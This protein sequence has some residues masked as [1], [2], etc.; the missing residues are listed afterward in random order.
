MNKREQQRKIREE[1]QRAALQREKVG[2][3]IRKSVFFIVV[4]LLIIF[5]IYVL[6]N[7][8]TTYSTTEIAE[9]DHVRESGEKPV[10][11]VVYADFQCPACATEHQTMSQAWPSIRESAQL[12]FRHFPVTNTHRHAWIAS[13]Y[14]EA[15]GKQN[16]FWEMHDYLFATQAI[17]SNLSEVENEFD[18]Y[19]LELNLDIEQLHLDIASEEVVM[20]VRNDLRGGTSSGV[21]GTPAVFVNGRQINNPSRARIIE[22]VRSE[23]NSS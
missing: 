10:S 4:P 14:A 12:V 5:S 19:A 8:G 20:K 17:W 23:I 6:L 13:L 15:A 21:R 7:Q 9:N 1:K 18:S 2:K 11:I 16:R 22:A 3:T